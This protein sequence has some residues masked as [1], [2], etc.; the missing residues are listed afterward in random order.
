M[1]DDSVKCMAVALAIGGLRPDAVTEASAPDAAQRSE[2]AVAL[3]C[4]IDGVAHAFEHSQLLS[5][6]DQRWDDAKVTMVLAPIAA[7]LRGSLP[8]P[9]DYDL[10]VDV[11]VLCAVK[12]PAPVQAAVVEWAKQRAN[13]LALGSP[14]TAPDHYI[15]ETPPGL[16]F[17][18][19]LTRWEGD[20]GAVYAQ[21]H[22]P[23]NID[24]E[25][26]ECARKLLADKLPKLVAQAGRRRVLVVEI[27][28][29]AL[30]NAG[31]AHRALAAELAAWSGP[32]PEAVWLFDG[33][34]DWWDVWDLGPWARGPGQRHR[35]DRSTVERIWG[36]P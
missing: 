9:G 34:W 35:V 17:E 24:E 32:Q 2:K 1:D 27:T 29:R 21:R 19:S 31:H 25:R 10:T 23:A 14:A 7:A 12:D 4:K 22:M 8:R 26:R 30:A 33:R 5:F 15:R 3:H 28:D 16:G 20:D 18:V 11:R 6:R 13:G 36:R